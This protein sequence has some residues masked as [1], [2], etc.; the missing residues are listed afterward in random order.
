VSEFISKGTVRTY[1]WNKQGVHYAVVIRDIGRDESLR[2]IESMIVYRR[3]PVGSRKASDASFVIMCML[4]W[5][6]VVYGYLFKDWAKGQYDREP[7]FRLPGPENLRAYIWMLRGYV[8]AVF[9][10]LVYW[11]IVVLTGD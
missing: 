10:I 9:L 1:R 2:T 4:F 8:I 11:L 7:P 3:P 6:F 5:S